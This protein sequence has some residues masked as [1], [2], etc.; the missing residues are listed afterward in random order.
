MAVMDKVEEIRAKAR[1]KLT[2]VRMRAGLEPEPMILGREPVLE[3]VKAWR[4]KRAAPG[5]PA[6]TPGAP[7][8]AGAA[9]QTPPLER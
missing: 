8:P 4:E 5:A 7:A 3:R 1:T 9:R 2:E 6:P